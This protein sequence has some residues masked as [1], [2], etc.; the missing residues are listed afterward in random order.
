[1]GE[2]FGADAFKKVRL[3]YWRSQV[4][5]DL[6]RIVD[7]KIINVNKKT[8]KRSVVR[9]RVVNSAA[10]LAALKLKMVI[11]NPDVSDEEC[12]KLIGDFFTKQPVEIKDDDE[13]DNF[14]R[15]RDG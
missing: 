10:A 8:G 6:N 14:S 2:G 1:M 3:S 15:R 9:F 13:S 12:R 11:S 5:K 7:P 4:I